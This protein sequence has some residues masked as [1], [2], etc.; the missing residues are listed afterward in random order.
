MEKVNC[1]P[2]SVNVNTLNV[3]RLS[4][5]TAQQLAAEEVKDLLACVDTIFKSFFL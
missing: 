3:N 5:D 2:V 4:P 1:N